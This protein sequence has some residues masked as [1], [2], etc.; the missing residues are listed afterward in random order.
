MQVHHLSLTGKRWI[1]PKALSCDNGNLVCDI[2]HARGIDLAKT[3]SWDSLSD[4][5]LLENTRDAVHRIQKALDRKET[6]GIIG[7]Y[8]ADGITGVAQ[9][10]RFFR[11]QNIEPHVILPH[12]RKHGYGVKN[13][14]IEEMHA[15]D[16]TLCITVDTGITAIDEIAYARSL[17][18]DVIVT[19]H[20]AKHAKLPD[21]IIVHPGFGNSSGSGVVFTMLRAL[22]NN[23]WR[24][25]EVDS[26]LAAIGTIA[27]IVPL[28]GENRAI[29]QLGL[30]AMNAGNGNPIFDLAKSVVKSNERITSTHVG[31]RIA[32]RINAAGRLD[33]PMI[34][35]HALLDGGDDLARLHSL[36]TERQD[37]TRDMAEAAEA[38][39]R[40]EDHILMLAS[41]TFHPGIIGLIAGKLTE[42]YGRP[43][44]IGFEEGEIITCSLRS[45]P[46]Y[47]IAE[48][49]ARCSG[50]LITFGGHAQA[51]GCTLKQNSWDAFARAMKEDMKAKCAGRDL[52]PSM[53]ID[54]VLD[55][56]MLTTD[57]VRSL[58]LLEPF[59]AGNP[60]PRFLLQNQP[61]KNVRRVGKDKSHLQCIVGGA[62]AIGF[63]LGELEN[64]LSTH[65]DIVC[66]LGIDA[67]NCKESVQLF[68]EDIR[69]PTRTA[70]ETIASPVASR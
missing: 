2:A 51:A 67:W 42:K 64:R 54:A 3:A 70:Q 47:H 63:G 45:I 27:D 11:R 38:L 28:T 6:V 16:V 15:R 69:Q 44:I 58:S 55:P 66:R 52:A 19:D 49:L 46:E 22:K 9:L 29:V 50:H 48:A 33:D 26:A 14:F 1:L 20:H 23:N 65:A 13:E 10:V 59:G 31:F 17:G 61:L 8:D 7:D 39:I 21:A 41:Q 56:A 37:A 40:L 5:F 25:K 34:S 12:R 60:E 68:I 57:F 4:P 24:E 35:L 43:S 53:R 18:M 30:E 36:N 62:K 32:P